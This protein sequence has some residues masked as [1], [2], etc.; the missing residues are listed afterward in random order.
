MRGVE[1]IL[2]KLTVSLKRVLHD[3]R[4]PDRRCVQGLPFEKV[5]HQVVTLDAQPSSETVASILVMVTGALMV[6]LLVNLPGI[7]VV[8]LT[9]ASGQIDENQPM[10]FT[11]TF[12]LVPEAGTYFM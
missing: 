10:Q 7:L 1:A 5:V 2:A 6:S 3:D 9:N 4:C 8:E 12:H 11:Q